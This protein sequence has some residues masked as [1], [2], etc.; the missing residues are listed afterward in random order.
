MKANSDTDLLSM[1]IKCL[2]PLQI[3]YTGRAQNCIKK[4]VWKFY[5]AK[6]QKKH[7]TIVLHILLHGFLK[8]MI[9]NKIILYM[10]AQERS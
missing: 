4:Q 1:K 10:D 2:M 5:M 6:K 3:L 8:Q 9:V 7:L